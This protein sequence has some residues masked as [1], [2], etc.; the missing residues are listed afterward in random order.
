MSLDNSELP[1]IVYLHSKENNF[2]SSVQFLYKNSTIVDADSGKLLKDIGSIPE[3]CTEIKNGALNIPQNIFPGQYNIN[4]VPMYHYS[5]VE[6][7]YVRHIYIFIYPYNAPYSILGFK[8]GAHTGDVEH[9]TVLTDKV[10]GKII[11]VYYSAHGSA[12]GTWVERKDLLFENGKLIVYSALGSHACY[13]KKGLWPRIGG[14]ANDHTDNGHKWEKVEEISEETVWNKNDIV[15]GVESTPGKR[16]WWK[17]EDTISTNYVARFFC[18]C[19]KS[20][21]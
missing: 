4:E 21:C 11:R 17:K 5:K 18:G 10:D 2:P 9:V 14:F 15:L 3:E 8:A 7:E 13:W 1:P 16:G 6:E 20:C 19:C 12:D